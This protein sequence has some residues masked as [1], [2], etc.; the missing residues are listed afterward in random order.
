MEVRLQ[1]Q[2]HTNVS[3][4]KRLVSGTEFYM[5][6]QVPLGGILSHTGK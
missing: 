6:W 1:L 5:V 4:R 3:I 2:I